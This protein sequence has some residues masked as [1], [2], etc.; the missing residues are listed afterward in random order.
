MKEKRWDVVRRER[1]MT[2][3][4][5]G[6]K[7]FLAEK[8]ENVKMTEIAEAAGF[9]VASLYRYF[10]TKEAIAIAVAEALW[11]ELKDEIL[12][13]LQ[14]DE[15]MNL[16]GIGRIRKILDC[17]SE[18]LKN[19]KEF[20]LFLA[21]FDAFCLKQQIS[22]EQLVE[23][24]ASIQDFYAPYVSALERGKEDGTICLRTEPELL[25]LTINHTML[26]LMEKI[27][28]GDILEQDQ[29]GM[30]EV[31]ALKEMILHYFI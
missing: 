12:P 1:M 14:S 17:Y 13:I 3:V 25:Y 16:S 10:E 20:L 26:T 19:H 31:E 27:A 7:L 30:E 21:D 15:Y 2:A 6:K 5:A 24:E 28:A 29:R 23:Y 8:I 11:Q 9:G 4:Q 22:K 18:I